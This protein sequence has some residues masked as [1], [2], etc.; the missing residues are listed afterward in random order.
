M[1]EVCF[2]LCPSPPLPSPLPSSPLCLSPCPS[3]PLLP[4]PPLP[5]PSLS[6]LLSPSYLSLAGTQLIMGVHGNYDVVIK[7]VR[8]GHL[9]LCADQDQTWEV[10]PLSSPSLPPLPSLPTFTLSFSSPL[11]PSLYPS[12]SPSPPSPLSASSLLLPLLPPSL[13]LSLFLLFYHLL[14]MTGYQVQE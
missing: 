13:S 11:S 14:C 4:S 6:P 1:F 8:Q 2:P 7:C 12:P 9:K 3:P 10:W 5:F